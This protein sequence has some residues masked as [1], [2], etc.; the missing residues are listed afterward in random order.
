[1]SLKNQWLMNIA[2]A[3]LS[4]LSL[5]FFGKSHFKRFLPASVL[6]VII[7]ALTAQLAKRRKWWVFYKKP[8]SYISGE[9]SFNIGPFFA[10]SMW[11][12]KWSYGNLKKFLLLNGIIHI[13]FVLILMN[14]MKKLKVVKILRLNELQFFFYFFFKAFLLYGF[15]YMI[16]D[17]RK[18]V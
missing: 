12:L 6:V 2:M 15:Q 1:M 7:E 14:I 9:L 4:W 13:F 18:F 11:V 10:V 5:S 16:G 17:K 3:L 8:K